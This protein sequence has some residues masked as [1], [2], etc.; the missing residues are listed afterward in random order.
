[1]ASSN[2]SPA[3]VIRNKLQPG[4]LIRRSYA[5]VYDKNVI[6]ITQRSSGQIGQSPSCGASTVNDSGDDAS[7]TSPSDGE[8]SNDE[9]RDASKA[10]HGGSKSTTDNSQDDGLEDWL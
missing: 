3:P 8:K 9:N 4:D 1:M 7:V 6:P 10:C 2:S 5:F